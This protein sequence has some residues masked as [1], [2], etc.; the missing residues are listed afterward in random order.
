[1]K[2]LLGCVV[3][4]LFACINVANSDVPKVVA[5]IKPVH[6]LATAVMK[7]VGEPYLVVKNFQSPHTYQILP[8]DANAFNDADIVIWL[9][10]Q[11]ETGMA[12]FIQQLA[13]DARIVE[14]SEINGLVKLENRSSDIHVDD[15]EHHEDEDN[16]DESHQNDHDEDDHDEHDH[17]QFDMHMWLDLDNAK[18]FALEIARNLSEMDTENQLTYQSNANDLVQRLSELDQEFKEVAR[19]IQEVPYITFHDAYQ[20]L[21]TRYNLNFA[22]SI[23]PSPE[24]SPSAKTIRELEEYVATHN[25]VCIFHEPQFPLSHSLLDAISKRKNIRIA[26]L[27]PLGAAVRPGPDAYFKLMRE[28]IYSLNTCMME[29]AKE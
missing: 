9:G 7:G 25:R 18:T 1:M 21:D 26:E 14:L 3:F 27:D 8:S 13:N 22:G 15:D 11:L 19:Q 24:Q 16:H 23:T 2:K 29:V 5:T 12:S 4:L 6:S 20:Y 28:M 10:P 17:G